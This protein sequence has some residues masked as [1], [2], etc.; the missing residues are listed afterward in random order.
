MARSRL[1]GIWLSPYVD[2]DKK[3][4]GKKS[5]AIT[6]HMT[7]TRPHNHWH[8]SAKPIPFYLC[9]FSCSEVASCFVSNLLACFCEFLVSWE[10]SQALLSSS[11]YF[12]SIFIV[13][14]IHLFRHETVII[15]WRL[16]LKVLFFLG[17]K[18]YQGAQRIDCCF[19]ISSVHY[20]SCYISLDDFVYIHHSLA[21]IVQYAEVQILLRYVMD[22]SQYW[23]VVVSTVDETRVVV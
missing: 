6:L 22:S 7:L 8:N 21:A 9:L 4:K 19:Y 16:Q 18:L 13:Q 23:V 20:V 15:A 2:N 17:Q 10:V 11:S 12:L 14:S 1:L 3:G 5:N